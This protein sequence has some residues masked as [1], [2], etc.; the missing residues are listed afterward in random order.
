MPL[1]ALEERVAVVTGAANGLGRALALQ[2]ARSGMHVV[3][4]DFDEAGAQRVAAEV[5][6]LGRRSLAVRAD[7]RKLADVEDV[8][9]QTLSKFGAC[10][11]VLNNAGVFH[12]APLLE[13]PPEQWQRVV[14]TNLWGVINGS[15][16]FG[17]Y[18]SKRGQGHIVNTASAAGLFPTPGMGAYSTTKFAIVAL[19]LQ[20][21]WELAASGVDVGVTVL[22]PGTLKTG[23]V[24]APGVGLEHTD[25]DNILKRA[26]VPEDLA[27]KVVAA[28]RKNKP[29][30]RFGPDAVFYSL[31]R[32]L[33]MWIVDPI[34]R[35][36]ARQSFIFLKGSSPPALPSSTK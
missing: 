22:C 8:L 11:V 27:P 24:H 23:I 35:F 5:E 9:A 2:L 13:A 14:D 3:A 25:I 28:I 31:L 6:A 21:R 36:M 29:M 12:A 4:A 18:F 1:T 34:G 26:P 17:V 7:V 19:S 20:L 32:L 33:P 15:R 16:V 10:D 30:L